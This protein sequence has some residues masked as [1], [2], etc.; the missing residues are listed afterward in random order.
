MMLILL[1][2]MSNTDAVHIS[3]TGIYQ[4]MRTNEVFVR[5]NGEV[6][7]L[8][9]DDA[10][11]QHYAADGRLKAEI[12]R[13]GRGPGEFTFPTYIGMDETRL[14]VYDR[15]SDMVNVFA[16]DGTFEKQ[17]K[18][19]QQGMEIQRTARG[20]FSFAR[21]FKHIEGTPATLNWS[22][23]GFDQPKE[24]GQISTTGWGQGMWSSYDGKTMRATFSP[25]S[26]MPHLRVS[27]DGKRLYVAD[28]RDYK[29]DIYDGTD[30]HLVQTLK[31]D[32]DRLPF[33][34]EWADERADEE[35]K[36]MRAKYP[37]AQI[38]K[39]YPEYFPAVRDLMFDTRG[40]LVVDRWR[41][42]PDDNHLLAT[43]D[44]DGKEV[45]TTDSFALLRRLCGVVDGHAFLLVFEAEGEAG[46]ARVPVAEAEAY[47]QAHPVTDW[48][49]ARNISI[50][51]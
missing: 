45:P 18:V 14:Y 10:K 38:N 28:A 23:D 22:T 7:L 11:V 24:A 46:L 32:A 17:I 37:G 20:W 50:S 1:L 35:T 27:P 21:S 16:L 44:H 9:F 15:L 31:V 33:D 47:V 12:G 34:T 13:K 8:N 39:L 30:G 49:Q 41:G 36:D 40:F 29:I 19:P 4:V 3:E 5:P 25:M 2:W 42:R 51:R 48:S 26:V 6:F 43:F